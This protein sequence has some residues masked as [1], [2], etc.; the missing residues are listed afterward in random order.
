MKPNKKA[1]Y[2]YIHIGPGGF[3]NVT[4]KIVT[5]KPDPIHICH[6]EGSCL[7]FRYVDGDYSTGFWEAMEDGIAVTDLNKLLEQYTTT[8]NNRQIDEWRKSKKQKI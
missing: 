2:L 8:E 1:L 6:G 3:G 7:V 5:K 4:I